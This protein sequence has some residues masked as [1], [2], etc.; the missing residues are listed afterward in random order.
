MR[1][2]LLACCLLPTTVVV[3]TPQTIEPVELL[4]IDR[5]VRLPV[6]QEFDLAPDGLRAAVAISIAG[7]SGILVIEDPDQPA[8]RVARGEV[9]YGEPDWSPDG[10]QLAFASD[11]TGTWQIFVTE[12]GKEQVRQVTSGEAEHRRPRWSPDGERIAF[13][14][15][16]PSGSGW[17]V[18]VAPAAGGEPLRLTRDP[19]DEEDPR[20][21]PDGQWIAFASRGGRHVNRRIAIVPASGGEVRELL[22][23]EWNGDSHSPRWAPDG[24]QVAF[25]S[26]YGGLKSIFLVATEG[27]APRPLTRSENEQTDPAWSPDGQEIAHVA[28]HEGTMRL[29]V[30]SVSEGKSTT[31]T[32][33]RGVY[34]TPQWTPDGQA[35][36]ALFSG[37]VYSPDVWLFEKG[38]GRRRLSNSLPV[39]LDFRKMARPELVHYTSWDDRT[40]SGYL[41]L[42][43]TA[44]PEEPA[45]LVVHAHSG[46]QWRNGWHPFVQFLAQQGFAV[47]VPNLR[48]S[49]GFGREFERLNDG[50]WGGG[51]LKDLVA[52]VEEL[53]G[54][55]EIRD[56]GVGLWGVGYGA[57]L[58]LAALGQH[59]D[60][61]AC[62]VEAMGMPDL[63]MLYRETNQEGIT[64]L[65]R[66]IGPLRGHLELYRKLSPIRLVDEMKAPLLTFH[67]ED[68]PVVPYTTKVAWLKSLHSRSY[69]LHEFVFKGRQGEGVFQL[70]RYPAVAVF[71]M[72]KILEFFTLYL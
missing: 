34:E 43:T 71:Y 68:Y 67:G 42:P 29:M 61:F 28:N 49:S 4:S 69:P 32:L 25:V 39:E 62:A 37:P 66:E 59:P 7:F 45:P 27:G 11:R 18:W 65:E 38:G 14:S 12:P 33:G 20:W 44:S 54:R 51:D 52:G 35:L 3:A 15:Q 40:I 6:I 9:R 63:V 64:Y 23:D 72:D 46:S 47:F 41:Y 53:T 48:G 50:D 24:K 8:V 19:L 13:L 36:A 55:P 22:P 56:S 26:D 10:N 2:C 1:W 30:T 16:Q 17:D 60:R 31:F 57:F 5:I 58:T 70:D 21:S